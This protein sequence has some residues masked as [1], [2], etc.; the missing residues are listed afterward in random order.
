MPEYH[1]AVNNLLSSVEPNEIECVF[2]QI[3]VTQDT[4]EYQ[5]YFDYIFEGVNI[6]APTTW[7]E[8]LQQYE[9]LTHIAEFGFSP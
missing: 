5:E 1:G 3:L 6:E 2:Q 8:A 9:K 4:D 7:K